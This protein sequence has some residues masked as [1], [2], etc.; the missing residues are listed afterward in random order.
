MAITH[1]WYPYVTRLYVGHDVN[2]SKQQTYTY[3]L[4]WLL[5]LSWKFYC[6]YLFQVT[7]LIEPTFQIL[8]AK[9]K[10]T[11]IWHY[12]EIA[13]TLS[14][15]ILWIPFVLVYTFDTVIWYFM[16]QAVVGVLVGM[17]DR[18]GEIREFSALVSAFT[19]LPW[20]FERKLL[21]WR[22]K[23]PHSIEPTPCPTHEQ[24]A[25]YGIIGSDTTEERRPAH[26]T[27]AASDLGSGS[28]DD[29]STT[30][31]HSVVRRE[32][33]AG[34]GVRPARAGGSVPLDGVAELCSGVE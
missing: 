21:A 10:W 27:A 33:H 22:V 15:F 8:T 20:E 14:I 16:F 29:E 19:S 24:Q 3:Q 4:F 7:P 12:N 28:G 1:F 13:D 30:T 18:L 26:T 17:S 9:P 34:R 11:H 5:L 23:E 6:S 2:E 31:S 25:S 32:P